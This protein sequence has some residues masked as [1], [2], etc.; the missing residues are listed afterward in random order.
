MQKASPSPNIPR[1]VIGISS[2]FIAGVFSARCSLATKPTVTTAAVS[3]RNSRRGC[4][5]WQIDNPM[6]SKAEEKDPRLVAHRRC[7]TVSRRRA[8]RAHRQARPSS[9]GPRVRSERCRDA[10][11]LHPVQHNPFALEDAGF[12]PWSSEPQPAPGQAAPSSLEGA[13]FLPW[14]SEPPTLRADSADAPAAHP[15]VF[16]DLLANYAKPTRRC[17]PGHY[18]EHRGAS[19]K[20]SG[21]CDDHRNRRCRLQG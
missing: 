7:S 5:H 1:P 2:K 4:R 8:R 3:I 13:G 14:S 21:P 16:G 15:S 20:L 11:R 9:L 18:A 6:F 17:R 10:R 12:L 19:E